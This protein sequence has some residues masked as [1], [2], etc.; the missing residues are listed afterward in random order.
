ML[1]IEDGKKQQLMMLIQDGLST[2]AILLIMQSEIDELKKQGFP[3]PDI[4][5]MMIQA[6]K[7]NIKSAS[8]TKSIVGCKKSKTIDLLLDEDYEEEA[9]EWFIEDKENGMHIFRFE[10]GENYEWL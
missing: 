9:L 2:K 5:L 3:L 7:L 4:A 10:T 8:L 6:L 1:K